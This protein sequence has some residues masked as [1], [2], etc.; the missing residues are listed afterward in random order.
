M[1]PAK[2]TFPYSSSKIP[3]TKLAVVD[4][5]LLPVIPIISA[6]QI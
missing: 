5:P 4:L 1:L 3:A 6:G 2:T